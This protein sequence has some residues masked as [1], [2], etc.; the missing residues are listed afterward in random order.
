M[1]GYVCPTKEAGRRMARH[2][3]PFVGPESP[4]WCCALPATVEWWFLVPHRVGENTIMSDSNQTFTNAQHPDLFTAR[5]T[6][7]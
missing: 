2:T 3:Y 6:S 7:Q 5:E 4:I 1:L